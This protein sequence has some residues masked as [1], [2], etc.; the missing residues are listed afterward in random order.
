MFIRLQL[1]VMGPGV[2]LKDSSKEGD[3]IWGEEGDDRAE[4][5]HGAVGAPRTL[6]VLRRG[7][8]CGEAVLLVGKG[9][10][11]SRKGGM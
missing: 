11:G 10:G 1:H 4:G 2:Q 3:I 7:D 6:A 9:T 8:T 5:Q